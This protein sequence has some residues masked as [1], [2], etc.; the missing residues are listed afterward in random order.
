[1]DSE[2]HL[3]HLRR[4]IEGYASALS[5]GVDRL[6]A[7]VEHCG[8][9]TVRDLTHHLGGIHRWVVTAV[10][11]RRPGPEEAD[12]PYDPRE[13]L[14]WFR[15]G[16]D[17]MHER[18]AVDPSTPA[19]TFAPARDV[20]FWQRRQ[21]HENAVHRWDLET[22]LAETPA[23]DAE[24]SADGV[25]E[26]IEVFVPRQVA[27]GRMTPPQYSVRL[28]ATDTGGE[29]VV[30]PGEPVASLAGPASALLL[31][32]WQRRRADGDGGPLAWD[33]DVAAGRAVLDRALTP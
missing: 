9:W 1:M 32:L 29:W 10:R 8:D 3:R 33:G 27:R 5:R 16:A 20:A 28:V 21:C 12:G 23:L 13:L 18:L 30:G 17:E 11:D 6:A 15:R 4:E 19:W 22:A 7:S 24:L 14:S 2:Q 31:A 25:A 26:V